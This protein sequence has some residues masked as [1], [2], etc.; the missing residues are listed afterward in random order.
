M[1]KEQ[2]LSEIRK[3]QDILQ[4]SV[5]NKVY[6][7]SGK[8]WFI[9]L[10]VWKLD[11][12]TNSPRFASATVTAACTTSAK[13]TRARNSPSTEDGDGWA[14]GSS[15]GRRLRPHHETTILAKT[16]DERRAS[17]VVVMTIIVLLMF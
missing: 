9:V 10:D 12:Y 7:K 2:S 13:A 11:A 3:P 1:G 4:N 15:F 16:E 5:D 14:S 6:L 8:S 17:C